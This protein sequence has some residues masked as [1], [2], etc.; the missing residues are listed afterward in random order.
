MSSFNLNVGYGAGQLAGAPFTTGKVFFVASSSDTNLAYID[1]L[2]TPDGEGVQRRYSTITAALAACTAGNGDVIVLSPS[3]TTA[4]TAAE[5]LSAETKGVKFYNAGQLDPASGTYKVNRATAALPQTTQ[6]GLFTVTG[7]IK[8]LDIKGVVT[9]IIQTQANNTKLVANP[10]VGADVDLCAVNDITADAVG[11]VY[12]ITGTLANA[13]VATTSGA[14]VF[15]AAPLTIEA[16]TIDLSCAASN[17]G[18]VKWYV[19][20]LPID[21]GAR[22][23]AA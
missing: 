12:S 22:V 7:R 9:T 10:T 23:F 2:F 3:F 17:T 5:L 19:E 16:G 8:L 4:L 13:M 18:S 1:G 20:Y 14:G 21:P 15:Q 6:S 11:T